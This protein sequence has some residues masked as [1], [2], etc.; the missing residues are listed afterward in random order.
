LDPSK[1]FEIED[2]AH[3][4]YADI[5]FVLSGFAPINRYF[6]P[7]VLGIIPSFLSRNRDRIIATHVCRRWRNT[8]LSTP[9]LWNNIK[10]LKDPKMT[11]AYLERSRNS[12]LDISISPGALQTEGAS[13]SL[14]MLRSLS[15]QLQ[16]ARFLCDD[17]ITTVID[18]IQNP[19]PRLVELYLELPDGTP[20]PGIDDLG[21]FPSLKSL[22]FIGDVKN[23]RFSKPSNIRKL[24]VGYRHGG[25]FRLAS[26]LPLLAGTPLLEEFEFHAPD[27]ES[28][29]FDPADA[30]NPVALKHLQLLVF[31]GARLGFPRALGSL[32]T[33][34]DH[35]KI[36]VT[37]YLPHNILSLQV[38]GGPHGMFPHGMQL[39]IPTPPK[40]IRYW[41]VQD[42]DLSETRCYIDLISVDD[43]HI[44]IENCCGWSSQEAQSSALR[45]LEMMCLEFLRTLDLSSV[46]RFYIQQSSPDPLSL[47][48]VMGDMV[49][50]RTLVAVN[51]SPYGFFLGLEVGQPPTMR[52]PLLRRLVF[53]QGRSSHVH[54]HLLLPIVHDRA[55]RG[56]PLEWVT[57]TSSFNGL[58]EEPEDLV[59]K[60]E[61]TAK[62]TYDLGRNT[63]GWEWWEV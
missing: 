29:I 15:N 7:E 52:C 23:L 26:L 39:P 30:R 1:I 61:G 18:I 53:R 21:K 24:G 44:S 59:Q 51:T 62:V 37:H 41:A 50:L 13:A 3:G 48:K 56:S 4:V 11:K 2:A 22:T 8:F 49:N 5:R 36:I 19:C 54:W 57:L 27:G 46:E 10:T 58:P 6:S 25:K 17:M 38:F 47:G 9:S 16:T 12:P 63:F 32:I 33:Y 34:P 40:S 31:R 14:S 35:T 28:P 60:L 43:K 55:A 45:D 20:F 42:V